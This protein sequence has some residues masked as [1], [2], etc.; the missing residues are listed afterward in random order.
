MSVEEFSDK[1][2]KDATGA[3]IAFIEGLGRLDNKAVVLDE[4][5]LS[6]IRV[7]DA[8]LRASSAGDLFNKSIQIGSQAWKENT[9]LTTEASQRYSTTESQIKI[10]KNEI[11]DM[12]R[13]IGVELLPIVKDGLVIVKDL[14]Q[15]FNELSPATKE[16]IIKFAIKF[17]FRSSYRRSR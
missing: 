3:L 16:N 7:R 17:Y 9:A 1:F 11:M 5:G 4:L 12:A 13:E 15:K 14:I 6:E 2:Q 8:L 10:L